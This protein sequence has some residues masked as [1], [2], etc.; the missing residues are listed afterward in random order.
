MEA[1]YNM[2][3]AGVSTAAGGHFERIGML[4]RP[5]QIRLT[6]FFK[7]QVNHLKTT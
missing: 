5:P 3:V 1:W 6:A 4:N 2:V 7:S